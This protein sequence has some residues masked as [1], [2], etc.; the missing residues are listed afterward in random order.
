[1]SLSSPSPSKKSGRCSSMIQKGSTMWLCER[2]L[3]LLISCVRNQ[4]LSYDNNA[5]CYLRLVSWELSKENQLKGYTFDMSYYKLGT[6]RKKKKEGDMYF[7]RII[8]CR[9][10]MDYVTRVVMMKWPKKMPHEYTTNP[11]FIMLYHTSKSQ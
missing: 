5:S 4:L 11:R 3:G 1:M 9:E 6:R 2:F 7:D 8:I 10:T